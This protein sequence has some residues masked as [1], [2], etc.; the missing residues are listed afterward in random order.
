MIIAYQFHNK[1]SLYITGIKI[2]YVLGREI[3]KI[4]KERKS[5]LCH[6]LKNRA[7]LL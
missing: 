1:N 7:S 2:K 5:N 4:L 3:Q 6:N